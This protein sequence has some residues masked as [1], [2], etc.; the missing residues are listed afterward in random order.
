[1]S[2]ALPSFLGSLV[3]WRVAAGYEFS[4]IFTVEMIREI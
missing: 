1:M 4:Y 3:R 2:E